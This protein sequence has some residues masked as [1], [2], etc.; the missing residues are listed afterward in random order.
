[1]SSDKNVDR[2]DVSVAVL[3]DYAPVAETVAQYLAALRCKT[4]VFSNP[5]HFLSELERHPYDIVVCDVRMPE[6][7]GLDV[8]KAV[9]TIRPDTD[10]IMISAHA[11]K[12]VAIAALKAGAF[13][14]F[15]KPVDREELLATIGRTIRFR[16]VSRERDKLS[17]Q[18]RRMA[19][20]EANRWDVNGI[21]GESEPMKVMTQ[22]LRMV[23]KSPNTAVLITGES[24]TGKEL[25]ARAIH[26]SGVRANGPF[27]PV[28]CSAV[29]ENLA[30]SN[31]FGHMKG[32]F[33]GAS[34]DRKG[35][36]DQADGGTLF[37][38]E[39][40]DMP[41]ML[42]TK[43]LRVLEDG[44]V[45][46]VGA[47]NG[48]EVRVGI[49]AATN[50]NLYTKIAAGSFRS[51]LYYRLAGFELHVPALRERKADIPLLAAHFASK[52]ALDMGLS[53]ACIS[54]DALAKI[55]NHP[56]P[57]NCREL[58]N[59]IERAL[60]E[61]GGNIESRHLQYL[62]FNTATQ[63]G[64]SSPTSATPTPEPAS[65]PSS[66]PA[67]PLNLKDLEDAAIKRALE[68]SS[69]NISAAAR[70]LGINRTKLYRRTGA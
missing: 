33:T 31:F 27:V 66:P 37:L 45:V 59:M 29:P 21:I 43:L 5:L 58:R 44:L 35:Y 9:K 30:E 51:D 26:Y 3:D 24:G 57:G 6:M 22:R 17:G 16:S 39:I 54:P 7:D 61:S 4:K 46:P 64:Q 14:F 38:D 68:L 56:F 50:V 2:P 8:L 63:S 40:G 62:S 25:V 12:D 60:I 19:E 67:W 53:S 70:L 49:V 20:A 65:G 36:F 13:D 69:G 52:L 34:D 11:D 18:V 47:A 23:A 48:H 10:M 42:Q 28:N 1:M 32:A 41:A 15:E 55:E